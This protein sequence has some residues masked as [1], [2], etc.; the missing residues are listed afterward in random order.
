M[1]YLYSII[2]LPFIYNNNAMTIFQP[3]TR[4]QV[5]NCPS[6]INVF[7]FLN[8]THVRALIHNS[9]NKSTKYTDTVNIPLN[10]G[11]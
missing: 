9:Y 3:E 5:T 11:T 2:K 4:N 1:V 7:D 8:V 6:D 10:T